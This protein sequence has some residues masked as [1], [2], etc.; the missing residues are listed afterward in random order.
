MGVVHSST[1]SNSLQ[2]VEELEKLK[3]ETKDDDQRREVERRSEQKLLESELVQTKWVRQ[4]S[5]FKVLMNV[6]QLT[7][8]K[9]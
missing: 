9:Y 3:K 7:Y 1:D 2:E 6:R 8:Y 4:R 5:T